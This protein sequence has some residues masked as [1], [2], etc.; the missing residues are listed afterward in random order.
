MV[1]SIVLS[2]IV[3][4]LSFHFV[5]KKALAMKPRRVKKAVRDEAL[6]PK[7]AT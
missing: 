1:L 4:W 6:E 7:S 3:A 5:E 2:I